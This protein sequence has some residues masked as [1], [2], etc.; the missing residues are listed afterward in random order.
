[1]INFE[2]IKGYDQG[3]FNLNLDQI[4]KGKPL[5][6]EVEEGKYLIDLGSFSSNKK[7][8]SNGRKTKIMRSKKG[9][10]HGS[11]LFSEE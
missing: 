11:E 6:F 3:K 2:S 9:L 8:S 10:M 1:M 7:E 4:S 5:V